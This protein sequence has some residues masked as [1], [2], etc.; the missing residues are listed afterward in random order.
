MKN[1]CA[2]QLGAVV[3][4]A[5]SAE[6]VL[7][8]QRDGAAAD[9]TTGMYVGAA[10]GGSGFKTGYQ[11][12]RATIIS[13]GA[14][15]GTISADAKDSMWKV[16]LGY[17]FSPRFSIEGGY[18]DF[19]KPSYTANITAPVATTMRRNFSVEGYGVD[20]V[21]WLPIWNAFTGF[22]KVGAIRTTT[23]AS[24]AD[25][26]APLT[27]LPADYAHKTNAHWGVGL[28]YDLRHDLAGRI[29][30]ETV[31]K[32]GDASKFGDADVIMWSLGMSYKF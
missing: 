15:A 6:P 11:K 1:I 19:G 10:I 32:V 21:L 9:K 25:P 28:K 14:A 30:F 20:A 3:L 8:Q 26:G 2:M 13:T 5:L 7:A 18:W 23:E 16:Y 4:V 27:S 22:Y 12:T 24:G 31:R 17:Q 29:E